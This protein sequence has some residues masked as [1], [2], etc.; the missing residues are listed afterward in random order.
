MGHRL[1][2]LLPA[3]ALAMLSGC[4]ASLD[5]TEPVPPT[6]ELALSP[7]GRQL[8]VSWRKSAKSTQAKLLTLSG[9]DVTAARD[10]SLPGTTH[11]T[12]WARSERQVLVTTWSREGSELL[13]IDLD[14]AVPTVLYK[15]SS[16]L[17][18]PLELAEGHYVVLESTEPG[19]RY[20]RWQRLQDGHKTL[21]NDTVYSLAAPLEHR[22]GSLYVL[23]PRSPP[24]FRVLHGK[25][26]A[27][28]QQL[29]VPTTWT[30][31]CAET[32]PLVCVQTHNHFGPDGATFGTMEVIN[33]GRRCKVPGRWLDEREISVSRDGST[34]VF[35]AP[36][37][38][39]GGP[40]A[41]Y[42][43]KINDDGCIPMPLEVDWGAPK[44]TA[45]PAAKAPMREPG[46]QQPL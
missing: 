36:V 5:A 40:R 33:G 20:S 46:A 29:I 18:F 11:T 21:L 27:G 24:I 2:V 22:G 25:L 32:Q 1:S 23:E 4:A 39:I 17:R 12:A 3:L 28:L 44:R 15:S 42:I 16:R 19:G 14:D 34:A 7:D 41:I 43:L 9:G 26:P 6:T 10:I 30:I 45:G 31:K 13:K 38:S 8:L 37:S 35:H